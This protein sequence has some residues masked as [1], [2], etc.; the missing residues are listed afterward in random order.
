MKSKIKL[1]VVEEKEFIVNWDELPKDANYITIDSDGEVDVF[2]K[3]PTTSCS[4]TVSGYWYC[5]RHNSIRVLDLDYK[6]LNW[7]DTLR[8][9]KDTPTVIDL[10]VQKEIE[11]EVEWDNL[12][13]W[14][15]YVAIDKDGAVCCYD[16]KPIDGED[17]WGL[18]GLDWDNYQ[19]IVELNA[20]V[21]NWQ[22]TLTSR[23]VSK[24][25]E[26]RIE[27]TTNYKLFLDCPCC[28][29]DISEPKYAVG[30]RFVIKNIKNVASDIYT[31]EAIIETEGEYYYKLDHAPY[32]K[33]ESVLEEKFLRVLT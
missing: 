16:T 15:N 20:E 31:V 17:K 18:W 4:P 27:Y 32:L 2:P 12:P 22:E 33:P 8:S 13:D 26:A 30:D 10:E 23:P 25:V 28:V 24:K 3:A 14:A 7:K 6:V 5:S 1:Q 21:T 19:F 11:Y 29:L 9:R